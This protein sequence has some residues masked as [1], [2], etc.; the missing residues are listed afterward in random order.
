MRN[1]K[2]LLEQVGA[3]RQILKNKIVH[4]LSKKHNKCQFNDFKFLCFYYLPL[5][6]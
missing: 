4:L 2:I 1:L 3:K 6:Y 5:P